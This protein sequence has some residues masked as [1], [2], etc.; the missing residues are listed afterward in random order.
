M[1]TIR[2]GLVTVV[3][4]MVGLGCWSG[5]AMAFPFFPWPPLPSSAQRCEARKNVAAG[6]KAACLSIEHA[7]A[8]EE[9]A[10]DFAGCEAAFTKGFAW[11]EKAA[12]PGVC[13]TEGD[14]AAIESLVDAC[15]ANVAS[16]LAGNPPPPPCAQFPATGQTTCWNSAGTIIPCMGTGQDGDVKAGAVLSYTDNG[17]GTI[18][19]NNTGLMW[20]KTSADGS[21]HDKDTLYTWANAFAVHIATL[22]AGAG[23]AG[24]TDWRLPNVKEL[25]SIV[26]YETSNPA[27]S[28]AFNTGCMALCTVSTCSC[29]AARGY[30]SSSTVAIPPLGPS[31][32][33][34]VVFFDGS[35]F[36]NF[37]GN[38]R[39]VRAVRG[40]L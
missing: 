35:I 38:A 24:H 2:R 19:D 33:W 29:T 5:S 12:G 4:A 11:A 27:V 28:P 13:P 16:A 6:A 20:E 23:F 3:M 40:G 14:T 25:Q 15:M 7:K 1:R 39:H 8:A 34:L 22:N 26:N 37:K 9:K 21:I 36:A 30:W 31:D 17:D 10:P 32:A 18:T